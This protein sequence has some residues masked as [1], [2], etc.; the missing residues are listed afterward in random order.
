MDAIDRDILRALERDGRMRW[1]ELAARVRLSP[2]AAA[3]RVRRLLGRDAREA[4]RE[5][6]LHRSAEGH[7]VAAARLAAQDAAQ[8]PLGLA[9]P[10]QRHPLRRRR[11]QLAATRRIGE[12]SPDLVSKLLGGGSRRD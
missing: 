10:D 2:N 12:Q 5:P 6:A 3:E 7:V 8:V 11:A 9:D 1:G 4:G